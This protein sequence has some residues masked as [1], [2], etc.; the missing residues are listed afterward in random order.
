MQDF[1]K[2]LNNFYLKNKPLWEIDYSWE[3]FSWIANDDN[4][5]SII[6]FRRTDRSGKEIIAV[7]NFVPV[8]RS[9]YRIGLPFDAKYKLVL[10]TDDKK[11]GG[12]DCAVLSEL[13]AEPIPMHSCKYSAELTLPPLSVLYYEYKPTAKR[14]RKKN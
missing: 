1:V 12:N 7:C 5:Q 13:K 6:S 10:N 8:A 2:T 4:E 14:G 9:G 11:Y 3:G